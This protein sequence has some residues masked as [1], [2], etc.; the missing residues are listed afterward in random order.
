MCLLNP[1]GQT[2]KLLW[3]KFPPLIHCMIYIW[4]WLPWWLRPSALVWQPRLLMRTIGLYA[5]IRYGQ[6]H[7]INLI[8]Y[9]DAQ[10]HTRFIQLLLINSSYG[11]LIWGDPSQCLRENN[12]AG[13]SQLGPVPACP[14]LFFIFLHFFSARFLS[15][16]F[17][18]S[19]FFYSIFRIPPYKCIID[20]F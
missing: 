6:S 11:T 19:Q 5:G 17:V 2:I 3:S 4:H 13:A 10:Y 16:F 18:S 14:F 7:L 1:Y 8:N 15:F 12:L 9:M 20:S